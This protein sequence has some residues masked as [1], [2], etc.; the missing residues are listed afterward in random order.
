MYGAN[1]SIACLVE[2]CN[3]RIYCDEEGQITAALNAHML[4]HEIAAGTI[5]DELYNDGE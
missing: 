2:G 1:Y 5:D 4:A 3:I